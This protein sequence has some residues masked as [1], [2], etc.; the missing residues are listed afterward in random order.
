MAGA[1]FDLPQSTCPF[2]R[3]FTGGASTDL[4]RLGEDQG[5]VPRSLP[6]NQEEIPPERGRVECLHDPSRGEDV[7]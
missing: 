6:A 1:T 2:H 5:F 3:W 7:S 4:S